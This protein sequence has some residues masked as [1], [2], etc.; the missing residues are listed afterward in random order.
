[1]QPTAPT[2]TCAEADGSDLAAVFRAQGFV[3]V[4]DVFT[5]GEVAVMS[6]AFD[7]LVHTAR[8]LP[9]DG[10]TKAMHQGSQFVVE[11]D[12]A[13]TGGTRIHRVVW[14]GAAAPPLLALGGDA[15]LV[16]LACDLMGVDAVDQLINQAHFKQPGDRI[17]FPWHQDSVH[18]RYGTPLWTDVT[19][20]GSFVEIATAVD[21]MAHD[22]GPLQIVPRSHVQGHRAQAPGVK[23]VTLT[24][25]EEARAVSVH[26]RPGDVVAFGPYVVHG[27][28]TNHSPRWRRLFLNGFAAPGANRRDYPGD[29]SGRRLLRT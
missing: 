25:E 20:E 14:C 8:S 15:R 24:P 11:H 12:P 9:A 22:N 29:G 2:A 4:R 3:I 1:M 17:T 16:D 18:R 28:G 10:L 19:G 6:A 7:D 21:L 26:L 13:L 5:A 23:H 27:S